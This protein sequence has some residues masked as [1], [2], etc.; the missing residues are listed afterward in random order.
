MRR[1]MGL[2]LGALLI[3]GA[4]VALP[5][6]CHAEA[7]ADIGIGGAFTQNE[8]VTAHGFG[9]AS[10]T[11]RGDFA[12]SFTA[13][14][15]GGYWFDEIP[16][17]GVGGSVSYFQP[18]VKP[19]D[20]PGFER[21]DVTVVPLTALAM[22]RAPVQVSRR[23]PYGQIQPYAAVGPGIF[24]STASDSAFSATSVDAGVD[25][26][27]G[28]TFLFTPEVGMF[29]EYRFTHFSPE[30]EDEGRKLETDGNT[31]YFVTG[32]SLRFY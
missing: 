16:W 26:H 12:D 25:V 21:I 29:G 11:F 10:G 31:H 30:L 14:G 2:L 1:T 4:L 18:D 13:G 7:F 27:A 3:G 22:F 15:R 19:A 32:L 24:I 20:V 17:F 6:M 8:D 28:V 23:F 9:A 5:A